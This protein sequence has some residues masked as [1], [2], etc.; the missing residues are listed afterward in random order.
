MCCSHVRNFH[1]PFKSL[2]KK[3]IFQNLCS[4]I[5]FLSST[6]YKP[7]G[8]F[9]LFKQVFLPL[10]HIVTVHVTAHVVWNQFWCRRCTLQAPKTAAMMSRLLSSRHLDKLIP[11]KKSSNFGKKWKSL[12]VRWR[13][14]GGE[15]TVQKIPTSI[16]EVL[17]LCIH[18]ES[19][20][21]PFI[22]VDSASR[23][24]ESFNVVHWVY[25]FPSWHELHVN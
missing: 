24:L 23:S 13:F 20:K 3:W 1:P 19:K 4:H 9:M 16:F 6:L 12:G 2:E 22:A 10:P 15:G 11:H 17:A 18:R 25:C 7:L 21:P 5:S 8:N 14:N